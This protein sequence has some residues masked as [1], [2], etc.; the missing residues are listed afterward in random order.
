MAASLLRIGRLNCIKCL[1]AE[2]W[3]ALSR[4]PTAVA[5][6]SKSGGS[7]K[8]SKKSSAQ[9][10]PI[11]KLFLDSIRQ[12]SSQSAVT[13]GLVD[14]GAEYE[15]SLAEEVAKLQR[16]YGGGDLESFPQFK[17]TEPTLD[18]VAQK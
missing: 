5:F 10:D 15:K 16:L 13:G 4:A 14:A 18:E 17:F 8:P 12:Y 6:S 7:K 1:Q 2:S 3:L 11:Q 9:M